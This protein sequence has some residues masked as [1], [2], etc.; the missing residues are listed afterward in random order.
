MYIF[1]S[2]LLAFGIFFFLNSIH[3][4]LLNITEKRSSLIE[5]FSGVILSV[6]SLCLFILI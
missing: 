3:N 5:G 2:I 1:L 6:V 4:K